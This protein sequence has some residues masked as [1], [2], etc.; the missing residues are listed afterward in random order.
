MTYEE[1]T[2][3]LFQQ[4]PMFQR[5]GPAAYKSNLDGTLYVLEK[6]GRPD[7][8]LDGVIH[9]AGT[10]GKGSVCTAISNALVE[11]GF[12]VGLFTSPHLMDF[13]ERLLVCGEMP[14]KAWVVD[15]VKHFQNELPNWSYQPSFFEWTFGLALLW[16]VEEQV[17][18]VVLET[19]MG[20]RLDST[21]VFP[22]PLVTA[23]TNIGLDHQQFL[24]RDIRS[25]AL[26]K[27]GI[28][29]DGVPVVLGRMRPEAQ[30]VILSAAL[31][32]GSEVFYADAARNRG[33]EED[34][35]WPEN[36]ATTLKVLEVLSNQPGWRE[37]QAPAKVHPKGLGGRWEWLTPTSRLTPS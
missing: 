3:W 27:A 14:Q 37:W 13:R 8:H 31:R 2:G 34:P 7:L 33:I 5:T 9:V 29:K 20:G 12:R 22:T 28:L 21:N 35:N 16:F 15:R 36:E 17:D 19:G 1:A 30:S 10:N 32:T 11:T 26:E 25:I 24:G 23:I 6:M 18:A 4:L